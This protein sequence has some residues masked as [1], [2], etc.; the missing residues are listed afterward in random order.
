MERK[1]G[2]N[3]T[4]CLTGA[5]AVGAILCIFPLLNGIDE[6]NSGKIIGGIFGVLF[7]GFFT[8]AANHGV[9]D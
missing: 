3:P 4:G 2:T 9:G 6:H 8:W 7:F 5:F 1:D